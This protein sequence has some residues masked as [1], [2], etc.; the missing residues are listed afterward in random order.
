MVELETILI[1]ADGILFFVVAL[2][3]FFRL[4]EAKGSLFK[5][6]VSVVL[7]A[8]S[9]AMSFVVS[10]LMALAADPNSTNGNL[11]LKQLY[12]FEDLFAMLVLSFLASFAVFATYAGS[13][14]SLI[15][16]LIF[17]ISLLP[18]SYLTLNYNLANVV[19]TS[20]HPELFNFTPPPL[21]HIFYA[22]CGIPLGLLP[23]AA[24]SRSLILARRR[25]DRMLT[26]RS[27]IM[28]AAVLINEGVYLFYVF[29]PVSNVLS[30]IAWIPAALFLLFAVLKITSPI[31]RMEEK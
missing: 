11:F 12:V 3:L 2:V 14:R 22:V 20:A 28:F 21:T 13:K 25:K 24:F 26:N 9:A 4:K 16:V 30:I 8:F 7:A 15:I 23:L 29:A 10:V 1:L 31:K 27:A 18:P 17:L 6:R 5:A 19:V